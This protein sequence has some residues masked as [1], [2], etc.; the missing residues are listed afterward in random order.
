MIA[1]FTPTRLMGGIDV[2][3]SS[4]LRQNR[5]DICWFVADE[6][7]E[8]REEMWKIV[9]TCVPFEIRPFR[10]DPNPGMSRTLV[11]SYNAALEKARER[12]CA[13]FV[14][15]QDYFWVNPDGLRM[16]ESMSMMYPND[17]FTG[18]AHISTTPP[19]SSVVDKKSHFTIFKRPYTDRPST[20]VLSYEDCRIRNDDVEPRRVPEIEWET[21]WA[22]MSSKVLYSGIEF[23]EEYDMGIAYENQ[24]FAHTCGE[25]LGSFVWLDPDNV[26]FGL[27]HKAYWPEIE[28]A[29]MPA[30]RFNRETH[31]EKWSHR[32]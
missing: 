5:S 22:A 8:E 26:V 9:S 28:Q 30:N 31:L 11:K 14:S 2:G 29:D 3:V 20:K 4:L 12:E 18:V 16:F 13:F 32:E 25:Q 6:H 10:V 21:N 7:Y 17:L 24:A 19:V 15:M 1:V 23:D 27:P